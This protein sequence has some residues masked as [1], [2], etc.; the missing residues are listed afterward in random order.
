M[1]LPLGM[2]RFMTSSYDF[3]DITRIELMKWRLCV[4][5]WIT[6]NDLHWYHANFCDT[7]LEMIGST[8]RRYK[9]CIYAIATSYC[10]VAHWCWVHR[11]QV[12]VSGHKPDWD[13]QMTS[14]LMKTLSDISC[15]NIFATLCFIAIL[16]PQVAGMSF[17]TYTVLKWSNDA[18]THEHTI[19]YELH[20]CNHKFMLHCRLE[21]L[22]PQ[23]AGM[24]FRTS[25]VLKWSNDAYA[26]K[27]TIG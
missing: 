22:G 26:Y 16:G 9:N 3:Q 14:I 20:R 5:K 11:K 17:R 6:W 27:Y 18:Y 19:R 7:A 15:I 25:T 1:A 13:D 12:W 4:Y 10:I 24:I 21:V 2:T 8:C 23:Q